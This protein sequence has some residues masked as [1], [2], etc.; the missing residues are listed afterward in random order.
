MVVE[1]HCILF[2]V[3]TRVN[4][5]SYHNVKKN[6]DRKGDYRST[7]FNKILKNINIM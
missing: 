6:S 4:I 2:N 7:N 3:F 5:L 1:N